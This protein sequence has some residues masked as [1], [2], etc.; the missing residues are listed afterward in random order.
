MPETLQFYPLD[1]SS[2]WTL[3]YFETQISLDWIHQYLAS[4]LTHKNFIGRH[5]YLSII[6]PDKFSKKSSICLISSVY[7]KPPDCLKHNGNSSKV[8][9]F[10]CCHDLLNFWYLIFPLFHNSFCS[11]LSSSYH[12]FVGESANLHNGPH[13]G[14]ASLLSSNVI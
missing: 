4:L 3:K 8:H 6:T 9:T 2:T 11:P 13:F 7:R 10:K 14:R 1:L 12:W 5:D